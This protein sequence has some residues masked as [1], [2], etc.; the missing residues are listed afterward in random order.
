M[1]RFH[2]LFLINIDRLICR[3]HFMMMAGLAKA[4]SQAELRKPSPMIELQHH[5]STSSPFV[6]GILMASAAFRE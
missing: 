5:P 2:A 1:S 3:T 6:I 4:C